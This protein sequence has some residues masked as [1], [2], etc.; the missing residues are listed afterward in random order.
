MQ[1]QAKIPISKVLKV[2]GGAGAG[3]AAGYYATPYAF[4]YEDVPQARR[5]SAFVDAALGAVLAGMGR[6]RIGSMF[7][8]K[9][10]EP[11]MAVLKRQIALPGA[12][13][14]GETVPIAQSFLHKGKETAE[15]I[16]DAATQTAEGGIP[17]ALS[18]AL[19]SPTAR[20]A[21]AGA[22]AAG[23]A[24]LLTGLGRR[25]TEEEIRK[26]RSRTGMVGSDAMKYL[27]PAMVAGGLV[28]S[29]RKPGQQR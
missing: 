28:G 11:A 21:G 22:G 9:P 23:I 15:T 12:I 13:A 5:T 10:K 18:R 3:G 4:G 1:K 17:A 20:G 16:A 19:S 2:L 27:I 29:L 14:A 24:A 7:K 8:A 6:K 26:R 25:R